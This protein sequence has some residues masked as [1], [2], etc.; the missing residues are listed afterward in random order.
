MTR[1]YKLVAIN[2][3]DQEW[4]YKEFLDG[5]LHFGWSPPG[6]YLNIL[7]N[8]SKNQMSNQEKVTWRYTQFLVNRIKKGDVLLIQFEQPLRKL[9]IA[10]VTD[11]YD[12]ATEEKEDFNHIIHCKP[13]TKDFISI[14]SKYVTKSL[15]H[16]ITKRGQ[17]YQIYP[18]EAIKNIEELIEEHLWE[19][20]DYKEKL[21]NE[22]AISDTKTAIIE[23]TID[24]ISK[25]WPGKAFEYFVED[26]IKSIP[27]MAA[28]VRDSG[29]G[30]DL[31]IQTTDP[32]SNEILLE[33]IPVQCKNYRGIVTDKRP[34]RDLE[35]CIINSNKSLA[36]LF[37]MGQLEKDYL[38]AINELQEELTEKLQREV[39][40]AV[41]QQERIAEMYLNSLKLESIQ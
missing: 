22:I 13:I 34:I 1:F 31:L 26:L 25:K 32:L 30:W 19:K 39:K 35:K 28:A 33:G 10:E 23:T 5:R 15:R 38:N 17:Y 16:A 20:N 41:V 18:K 4:M 9:L 40:L 6:S 12:Y 37:I 8:K 24:M 36:Y 2:N 7:K 27:G 21:T 14:E 29:K 11:G 3:R